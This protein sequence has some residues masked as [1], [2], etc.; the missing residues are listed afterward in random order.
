MPI[1]L[2][3]RWRPSK[4]IDLRTTGQEPG[5][6]QKCGRHDLRF[7]HLIEHPDDGSM[8]VGCECAAR[9][10]YGYDPKAT[11][12][13]LRNLWA[14]RSRWL[15]RNWNTSRNG[16]DTL[17]FKHQGET[18]RVTVYRAKFGGFGCCVTVGRE[19][20]FL[21]GKFATTDEA[22]LTAFDRLAEAL[23]W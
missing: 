13:K 4:V 16:N 11:E 22:K 19:S 12:S 23:E 21:P 5:T 2:Q 15:T 17:T 8:Q 14:R 10:C 18:I 20:F 6:C 1:S 7:V 3:R 9:L